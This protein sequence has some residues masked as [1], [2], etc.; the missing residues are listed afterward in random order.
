MAER[1]P[2]VLKVQWPIVGNEVLIYNEDRSIY[3]TAPC[4]MFEEHDE[5]AEYLKE[6]LKTYIMGHIDEKGQ[7]VIDSWLAEQDYPSW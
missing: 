3:A 6:E 1:I 5:V 7:L 2:E 4:S